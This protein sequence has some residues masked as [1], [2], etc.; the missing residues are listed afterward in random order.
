MIAIKARVNDPAIAS[1]RYR[2]LTPI[3]AL[4]ERGHQ[5]ELYDED[6]FARYEAVLFSKAFRAEDQALARRLSA[7]GKRVLF[8]LCDNMF[9]NPADLPKYRAVRDDLQELHRPGAVD[10]GE[11]VAEVVERGDVL[12]HRLAAAPRLGRRVADAGAGVHG[13]PAGR[14]RRP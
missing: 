4:T 7:A 11:A 12:L 1:F 8:D 13:P 3:R 5:V 14:W 9:Y 10:Q 6:R 2:V